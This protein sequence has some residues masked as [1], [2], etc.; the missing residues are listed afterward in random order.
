MPICEIKKHNGEPAITIN[1]K[2]FPPMTATIR[3]D[4]PEY[5]KK[6]GDIGIR[7]FYVFSSMRWNNPGNALKPDGVTET[8][9][10]IT[11]ILEA[12]P[13]AYIILRLNVNPSV[14]WIN[15]HPEEQV[16]FN[17][18]SH[19]P[20]I[21]TTAGSEPVDG[22]ISFASEKW[23][24]EGATALR[25]FF[26]EI[27]ESPL[28]ERVIG[29]FLCA[30]GT[31][32]WYYPSSVRMQNN[33]KGTYADFSEPF[34]KSYSRF[35]KNKYG[36]EEELRRVWNRDDASFEHPIIPD[37]N[38]RFHLYNADKEIINNLNNW[39]SKA[40]EAEQAEDSENDSAIGIFL[41]VNKYLYT[42]DFFTALNQ[43]TADTII[44]FAKVCKDC[45]PNLL[46][47]A[48]YGY[49]ACTDYYEASHCTGVFSIIDSGCVDFLAGPGVY[50]N[51][52]PGGVVAQREMQ[53]SLRLHNM[54]YI[55]EDDARTHL[56]LPSIQR[57]T[58]SL[59]TV[60]DSVSTLKRDF[61]RNICEDV[62]GWW[63][64]MGRN[65][66]EEWYNHPDI[67]SL[68]KRQQ[69]ISNLSYSL[70]RTKKNEIA[71]IYDTESV[72]LVSDYTNKYVLDFFRTSDIHRIGAPVDYYFHNDLSNPNMPDYKLYI[73]LN[74]YCLS[75]EEREAIFKK[76][77]RNHATVLWLYAPGFINFK[78]QTVMDIKN[79]EKTVGMKLKM[80]TDTY[81]PWFK[82]SPESHEAVKGAHKDITYGFID[83]NIRSNIWITAT[84]LQ[85]EFSNPAFSIEEAAD[86]TVLGRYGADNSPALAMK[87]YN[88][89]LS[90]YC[91]TLVLRNDVIASIAE[92]SGCHIYS[93]SEDILYA[94]ENFVGIH[95]SKS[96]KK[97]I[98]FKKPCSPYEVYEKKYYG[99]N[100]DFIDIEMNFGETKM[101]FQE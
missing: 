94:N 3:T 40:Y 31:S 64:D 88:G 63:F 60:N 22:M 24:E 89:F 1:G 35:L 18:G 25:E 50:N 47:G 91:S 65:I 14:E 13:D 90:V 36:T 66:G 23:R 96:G 21:C 86:V 80:H 10:R 17:D 34:R 55:C 57:E 84:E 69:E 38:E 19:H 32:E 16:L 4:N 73:M 15:S 99:K 87:D 58:M 53:D 101:F 44:H 8:L 41:N 81:F 39:E 48:F 85:P 82:I 79:I 5:L 95:A 45:K 92:Y 62:Q 78:S 93:K 72:H 100:V 46:V 74:T 29:Y 56:S 77:S 71:L 83:R 97:R 67:L 51:R 59:Y 27:S 11:H 7:I 6:L 33:E 20:V 54:I 70:D 75:D 9:N 30:G 52:Q 28:F 26:D 61:A 49:F 98:H 68:F 37:I 2:P 12:V 43:A 42:A 76:A